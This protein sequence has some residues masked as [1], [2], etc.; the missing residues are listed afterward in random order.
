[1]GGV[2]TLASVHGN[3]NHFV[4]VNNVDT[5]QGRQE[6]DPNLVRIPIEVNHGVDG[7]CTAISKYSWQL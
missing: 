6:L 3:Y 2:L 5:M 4:I 1:M 7:R